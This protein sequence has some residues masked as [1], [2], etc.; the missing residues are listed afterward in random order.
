MKITTN[1]D[2]IEDNVDF[3]RRKDNPFGD[4]H[5]LEIAFGEEDYEIA[6][7]RIGY[8]PYVSYDDEPLTEEQ[9]DKLPY[10]LVKFEDL[11]AAVDAIRE[12]AA[13]EYPDSPYNPMEEKI[14]EI[15]YELKDLRKSFD[16]GLGMIRRHLYDRFVQSKRNEVAKD[17][18]P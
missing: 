8:K 12:Q 17:P 9:L 1:I 7:V 13:K 18:E 6:V 15:G 14:G 2:V 4:Y 11:A 5:T 16:E 10:F 3:P